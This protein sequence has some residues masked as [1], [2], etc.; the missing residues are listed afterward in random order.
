MLGSVAIISGPNWAIKGICWARFV[1]CWAIKGV[2]WGQVDAMLAM[3]GHLAVAM[4]M[5]VCR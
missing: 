4:A 1:L 5:S 2:C 3:L